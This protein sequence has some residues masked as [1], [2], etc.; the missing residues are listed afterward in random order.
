MRAG[1]TWS[2]AEAALGALLALLLLAAACTS[3]D[4][5]DDTAGPDPTGAATS[6]TAAA[7]WQVT[8]GDE[9]VTVDTGGFE[10]VVTKDPFAIEATDERGR[11]FAEAEGLFVTRDDERA[12]VDEV[13]AVEP[14]LEHVTLDVTFD[15]ETTGTVELGGVSS[16]TV[17]VQLV[18]GDPSGVTHWGEVLASPEDELIYGLTERIVDDIADSEWF[19]AEV[20]SLDRKGETVTMWVTPTM[21]GYVP[22]HQSS[23]GYGLLVD[24]FMAGTYDVGATEPDRVE[25]EFE[26]SPDE[27]AGRYY[28]FHGPD[29]ATILEQYYEL[30]GYAPQPP[31]HVF[32]HW[33]GR[34]EHPVGD[35][36]EVD[37]VAINASVAGDLRAY[38]EYG[39]P[40]GIYHLDRPW[41][42]GPEG[43]GRF[44]LDPERHPNAEEMLTLLEERGWHNMVW[45]AP[46]AIGSRGEEARARGYLAPDSDRAIDLTNPDAVE[47]LT[48]DVLDF[49][50]GP[51]GSHVDGFF[52]DRGDEPDVTSAVEHVYS[53]G[54]N[55]RQIHNW[56]PVEYARIFRDI[57]DRARPDDG[58]LLARPGYTGS[59]AHV[60]RWGGDTHARDG[61]AI[62]EAPPQDQ[63]ST[64]LGLRS[65]LISVQRAAF[66]G[67]PFWGHDI[68]GYNGWIDREVYARW[69]EIGFASPL[70]RFHGQGGTPWE[71]TQGG[72]LDEGLLDIYRRYVV[73]RHAMQ[74]YL[75]AAAE[76]ASES[77]MTMVRPLVFLWPD[78]EGARDRWDQWM[79]GD[80][81]LVAPVWES[82]ARNRTVWIP[83][84]EWV[85][86][87]DRATLVE[88]P[89][90]IEVDVPLDQLPMWVSPD[91]E[92]LLEVEVP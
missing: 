16:A 54:R 51:E 61:I 11:F 45:M 23:E 8:D 73:L 30:T 57:I 12:F 89:T 79:L 35:P 65:V 21:S 31:D 24:G 32:L 27:Q 42:V 87:W 20:G 43:F 40:A 53:D 58:F 41:A 85:D 39:L 77:G 70:M 29:H 1:S 44:E 4:S 88:G 14:G 26:M 62:P 5:D 3:D 18:P 46:W 63:P 10:V 22:F 17:A 37:G 47:W 75:V 15:D 86:F 25:L 69:I 72:G 49:L 56:Y 83:P 74:D 33:R 82:G 50:A 28:L 59:Q 67:T 92:L 80:D 90:E 66:M 7:S 38:D 68:G 36:V 2:R 60:M 71:P 9:E 64:D 55:G 48:Q 6:T 81:L 91:S 19:P 76:E 52:M 13:T 78:E 84:G 34:D